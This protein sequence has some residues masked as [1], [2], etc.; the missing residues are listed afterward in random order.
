MRKINI[1]QTVCPLLAALIWG[2]A[3]IAQSVSTDFIEPFTFNAIRAF[4]GAI[5][6]L[7][8]AFILRKIKKP[9]EKEPVDKRKYRKMLILGGISCGVVLAV[10][11]YLQQY[12]L[13][14]TSPGK[15]G[16]ITALYIVLVPIFGMFIGKK[17]PL[18]VWISV[19]M[20]AVGLYL[21]CIKENFTISSGD[22]F[23]ILCAVAFTIHILVIDYFTRFVDGVELSLAQFAVMAIISGI[24]MVL[25][26]SPQ[27]SGIMKCIFPLLYVGVFSNAIAYTLQIV[28]QKGAN[29]T[30]VTLILS[31]ESVF[32]TLAGAVL[33]SEVMSP[34]EYIGCILMFA[35][36]MLAQLPKGIFKFN[37]KGQKRT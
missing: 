22:T 30:V 16:F 33:L 1:R 24:C 28:A 35:A 11:S 29:P 8:V 13:G 9:S 14:T 15:A 5:A 31:L 32:A 27:I 37:R 19:A 23:V 21:L 4:I 17:A 20:S 10:A 18:F 36:V 2:T 25:F 3:F 26:E 12:G 34:K 7:P 6:L